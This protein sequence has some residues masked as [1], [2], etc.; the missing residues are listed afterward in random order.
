QAHHLPS[1]G[2]LPPSPRYNSNK[3]WGFS[4]SPGQT[5]AKVTARAE[6]AALRKALEHTGGNKTEAARVIGIS[7]RTL[8]YKLEKYGLEN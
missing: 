4:W 5:L 7:P 8:Y 1:L 2:N 3:S 6:E